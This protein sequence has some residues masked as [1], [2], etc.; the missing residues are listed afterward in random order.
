MVRLAEFAEIGQE[1]LCRLLAQVG[2]REVVSPLPAAVTGQV[3]S[4]TRGATTRGDSPWDVA[5][6]ALLQEG[7]AE[8]GLALAVIED[9]PPMDCVRLGV[10]GRDEELEWSL[11]L[12]DSMGQLGIGVLCVNWMAG[13]GWTRTRVSVPGRGGALVSSYDHAVF[14]RLPPAAVAPVERERLRESL[15]W[16]LERIAPAAEAASVRIALHPDDPPLTPSRG[17]ARVLTSLD[18][19]EWAVR[20]ASSPAVGITFCQG[21]IALMTPDVPQAIHRFAALDAIHFIHF[22]DVDGTPER[23]VE[24][25]H[26]EG[27]TDMYACMEAYVEAGVDA[28]LR[29]DHVPTLDG[30]SNDR[31]GY[32]TLGRLWAV[33]YITGLR[34]AAMKAAGDRS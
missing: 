20:I 2:V 30:E 19:L 27:P 25:F 24:T 13:A 9:S 1:R 15:H 29:C 18:D 4:S 32:A 14:G 16:F 12:V 22:R 21:N 7:F 11:R 23:F 31:P 8:H 6:L 5:P 34:E 26:D 33:G 3:T 10:E 17:V 28:P